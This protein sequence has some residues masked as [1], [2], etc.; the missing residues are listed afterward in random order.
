MCLAC[1][2]CKASPVTTYM[3][4]PCLTWSP[5]FHGNYINEGAKLSHIAAYL[6]D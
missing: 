2:R 1:L 5:G 3:D 4:V 6:P